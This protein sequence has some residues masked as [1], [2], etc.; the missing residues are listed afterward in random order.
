MKP[1]RIG[2]VGVGHLG[3]YHAE[4][5]DIIDDCALVGVADVRRERCLDIAGKHRC[6][7]F[8]DYRELIGMV[9]AVTIAVPTEAHCSVAHDF[10]CAGIDV[11]VEKPL[12]MNMGDADALIAAAERTGALLQVGFIERFN[13]AIEVLGKIITE[14]LF[15]E[16]DRLHPFFSRGTD[17]DVILD[18]MIHDLD[19]ILHFATAPL[20]RVEAV[21]VSV[22]SNKVDIANARLTFANGCIANVTASRVT[23]K[24]MQKI[25]FF[26]VEGYNSVDYAKRELVSLARAELSNG[27]VEI[28]QNSV[29][30]PQQDP[31]EMEMRAFVSSVMTRQVPA[32]SGNEG[33][34][35]L[36]VALKISDQIMKHRERVI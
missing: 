11:M 21:G 16:A 15:I 34:K 35:S 30:V 31:L 10:L 23:N 24:K 13:P 2:V 32:V 33:R 7:A 1:I 28:T 4:K 8:F 5:L 9:D 17:V 29:D 20:E 12:T 19:I 27:A 22:L 14:P 6:Q 3:A 25:R 26:G 36:D 18:L